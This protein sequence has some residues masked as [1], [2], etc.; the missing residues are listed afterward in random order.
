MKTTPEESGRLALMHANGATWL[1][2][3]LEHE[4]WLESH[5]DSSDVNDGGL[6]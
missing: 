3:L 4:R 1:Q 6:E 2:V 5:D